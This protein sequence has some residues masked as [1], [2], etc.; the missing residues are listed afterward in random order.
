VTIFEARRQLLDAFRRGDRPA[1][2]EVYSFYVDA[3]AALLGGGCSLGDGQR[4][5][6]VRDAQ[7][8]RDLL[9]EVFLKAFGASARLSYDGLRPYRPFLLRIARNLLVDEARASGRLVQLED[10]EQEIEPLPEEVSP[11]ESLD[12]RR[13]SEATREFCAAAD[14]K[15]RE[16]IRLRFEEDLSQRDAADKLNVTRR[17]IRTLEDKVRTELR[18]F[19]QSREGRAR[20]NPGASS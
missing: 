11:E 1:M 5:P 20:P 19:L 6:G 16:F 7:R 2:A 8:H 3:V 10:P 17:K 14:P 15:T 4:L 9:Q 12:W 13:L 18:Q